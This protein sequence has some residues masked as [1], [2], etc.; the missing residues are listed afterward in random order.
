MALEHELEN[1]RSRLVAVNTTGSSATTIQ[2]HLRDS[3]PLE[4][5]TPLSSKQSSG[6]HMPPPGHG[7]SSKRARLDGSTRAPRDFVSSVQRSAMTNPV[8]RVTET[9]RGHGSYEYVPGPENVFVSVPKDNVGQKKPLQSHRVYY[10]H[11]RAPTDNQL[12]SQGGFGST[13]AMSGQMFNNGS[14]G[15]GDR[16]GGISATV[17]QEKKDYNGDQ[18]YGMHPNVTTRRGVAGTDIGPSGGG[19][20]YGNIETQ[21]QQQQQN[22]GNGNRGGRVGIE[23]NRGTSHLTDVSVFQHTES[24]LGQVRRE[25]NNGESSKNR[26]YPTFETNPRAAAAAVV[27]AHK[28]ARAESASPFKRMYSRGSSSAAVYQGDVGYGNTSSSRL[29][30]PSTPKRR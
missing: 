28:I 26:G 20:Y 8:Q 10:P 19:G 2:S 3:V 7:H 13:I 21:K 24:G 30:I 14:R 5:S 15:V 1:L 4:T 12:L 22:Y 29:S 23:V 27:H 9:P 17:L 6:A 18:R 11:R 25:G 16:Y